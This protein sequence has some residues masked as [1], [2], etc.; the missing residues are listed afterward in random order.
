M[1]AVAVPVCGDSEITRHDVSPLIRIG[2]DHNGFIKT[3]AGKPGLRLRIR[4]EL[5]SFGNLMMVV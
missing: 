2:T 3:N 5:L 1:K 4:P